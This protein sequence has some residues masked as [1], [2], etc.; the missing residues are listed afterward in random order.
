MLTTPEEPLLHTPAPASGLQRNLGKISMA[1]V[2]I[3]GGLLVLAN[4]QTQRTFLDPHTMLVFKDWAS[5]HFDADGAN[6][7]EMKCPL[8]AFITTIRFREQPGYSN[9]NGWNHG[10]FINAELTCSD[11]NGTILN[12][13]GA[14]YGVWGTEMSCRHGFTGL[15]FS[16]LDPNGRGPAFVNA[17]AQCQDHFG[18]VHF[19]GQSGGN[20]ND[21]GAW[22]TENPVW[23]C[24]GTDVLAGL[25]LRQHYGEVV[26]AR[27]NC[28]PATAT[29]VQQ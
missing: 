29:I 5:S 1:A 10:F 22:I 8:P 28:R 9:S 19:V 11:G 3:G 14:M 27:I 26:N 13:N 21:D 6:N 16:Q 20:D 23:K 18:R 2:F 7:A 15:Q 4:A 17:R 12:S 25:Q 24:P